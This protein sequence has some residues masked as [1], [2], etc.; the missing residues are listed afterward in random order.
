HINIYGF[1]HPE[2][3]AAVQRAYDRGVVFKILIDNEHD[4]HTSNAKTIKT[5]TAMLH[6]PSEVIPVNN[7]A[8]PSMK[9]IDHNKYVL[10][11]EIHMPEGIA[12]NVVWAASHN[13]TVG[14]TKL[15]QDAV[16]M[17]NKGLY[18]AFLRDWEEIAPLAAEGMTQFEYFSQNVG[19]SI[20]T[21]F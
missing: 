4:Y 14:Q 7:D 12:K 21:F 1:T 19:D 17:T 5:L 6:S 2:V 20:R 10:F 9:A 18:D 13:F 15:L 11:S 16:V 3:L 8:R